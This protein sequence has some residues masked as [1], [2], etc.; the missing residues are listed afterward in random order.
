VCAQW[1][2]AAP[3]PPC[4]A[5]ADGRRRTA[6]RAATAGVVPTAHEDFLDAA[7]VQDLVDALQP[8]APGAIV[9]RA[10]HGRH[11]RMQGFLLGEKRGQGEQQLLGE[12]AQLYEAVLRQ[13]NE[14]DAVC[15]N[16]NVPSEPVK[17]GVQA[18]DVTRDRL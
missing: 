9:D 13:S 16:Q 5:A 4:V 12:H 17:S 2:R 11:W 15:L 6:A 14:I 8:L 10:Q 7:T 1:R 3:W 18:A